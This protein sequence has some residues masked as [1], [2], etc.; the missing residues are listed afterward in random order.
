MLLCLAIFIFENDCMALDP[1]ILNDFKGYHTVP[2]PQCSF[3]HVINF[4]FL[5]LC[6]CEC[7]CVC[8]C[9]CVFVL[10]CNNGYPKSQGS[11]L[12]SEC[13]D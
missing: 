1:N 2:I 13:L 10:I 6:V 12:S 5:F 11:P 3:Y 8:V 9:V 7:V 4:V